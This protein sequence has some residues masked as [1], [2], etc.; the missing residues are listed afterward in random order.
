MGGSSVKDLFGFLS[1]MLCY[2]LSSAGLIFVYYGERVIREM[3][4]QDMN[5]KELEIIYKK[6][7]ENFIEE[8]D[9]IDNGVPIADQEPKY[10][11]RT[12]LSSRVG[13]LNPEWNSKQTLDINNLFN[14]AMKLV[15]EEFLYT[16]NYFV[17]VWLPARQY[18]KSAIDNR[19]TVHGS[20][21][22]VEFTERFPWKEHLFDL[23]KEMELGNV[24]KYV[25]F[26]DR[27]DSWRVQAVPMT[28]GSFN[29]RYLI[30]TY[31]SFV[32][33]A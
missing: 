14:T 12:N 20:G 29:T 31:A 24:V 8:I 7:Y 6:V 16:I 2:R 10:K 28:S 30:I 17:S 33:T 32:D 4:N 1:Y 5:T 3:V 23:E 25:I 22:I 18:V 19:F 27:P 26:N 11:I 13:R 9:A 15:S 21:Q